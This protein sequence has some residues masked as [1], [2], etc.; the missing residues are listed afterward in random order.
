[1]SDPM[2]GFSA[3]KMGSGSRCLFV[4]PA[5]MRLGSKVKGNIGCHYFD[6]MNHQSQIKDSCFLCF[7]C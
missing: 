7:E 3:T 1:M 6:Y 4:V 5:D 2:T